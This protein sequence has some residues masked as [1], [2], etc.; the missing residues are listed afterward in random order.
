MNFRKNFGDTQRGFPMAPMV[1][2]MFLLLIFFM[3]AVVYAQF[4]KKMGVEVPA[5]DSGERARRQAGEIIINVDKEGHIFINNVRRTEAELSN[6]LNRISRQYAGQP[7]II[8]ADAKASHRDVMS[9]LDICKQ[10]GVANVAF[11]TLPK[12][13]PVSE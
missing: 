7:V 1:D 6:L 12:K 5:T 11:A 8:R 3:S 2:V 9:V 10:N 4:E 13:K